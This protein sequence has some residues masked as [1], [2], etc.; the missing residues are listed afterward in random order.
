MS[1]VKHAVLLILA[2]LAL[3]SCKELGQFSGP[4]SGPSGPGG[5]PFNESG[6]LN[7]GGDDSAYSG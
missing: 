4:F 7:G 2:A 6:D 1:R 3:A 5:D